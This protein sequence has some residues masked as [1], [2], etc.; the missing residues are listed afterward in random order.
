LCNL[1]NKF[2]VELYVLT[3]AEVFSNR[4]A[5]HTLKPTIACSLLQT[6]HWTFSGG[7]YIEATKVFRKADLTAEFVFPDAYDIA[8]AV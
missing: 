2:S 4:F 6:R 3:P 1:L 7:G 5:G 8:K